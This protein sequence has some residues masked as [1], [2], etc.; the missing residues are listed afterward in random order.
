M[1]ILENLSLDSGLGYSI[2]CKRWPGC[3]FV[4]QSFAEPM[5]IQDAGLRKKV[6]AHRENRSPTFRTQW[7]HDVDMSVLAS[8]PRL[9]TLT[10]DETKLR[11]FPRARRHIF[12][13]T[14]F[15]HFFVGSLYAVKSARLR[16]VDR[17]HVTSLSGRRTTNLFVT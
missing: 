16:S 10:T 8:G 3:K 7:A 4:D 14:S 13:L 11:L 2:I 1:Y 6:A 5:D 12:G 15:V 17:G 9:S